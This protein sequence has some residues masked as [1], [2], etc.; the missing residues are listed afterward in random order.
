MTHGKN[1]KKQVRLPEGVF[2]YQPGPSRTGMM[3]SGA[4]DVD[5]SEE[6]LSDSD[7]L[8]EQVRISRLLRWIVI[9]SFLTVPR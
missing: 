4:E 7:N 5:D 6:L 3:K 1:K 9:K 2:S 8:T